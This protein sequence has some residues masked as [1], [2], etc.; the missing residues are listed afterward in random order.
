[1]RIDRP[2]NVE[3]QGSTYPNNTPVQPAN[4]SQPKGSAVENQL[5][6]DPAAKPYIQ[7]AQATEDVNVQAIAEA[8]QLIAD[9]QLDT[10]EAIE[11]LAENLL[12]KGI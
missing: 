7:K 10:T 8:K 3:I 11:K 1:M 12:S 4:V 5:S 2:N 9:G 6:V